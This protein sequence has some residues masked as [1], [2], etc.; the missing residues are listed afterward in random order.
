[1]DSIALIVI[2]CV[3]MLGCATISVRIQK[4][5]PIEQDYNIQDNTVSK[6]SVANTHDT[7]SSQRDIETN[8]SQ[9]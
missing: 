3:L 1:M 9:N 7:G 8:K 4:D 6:G 5:N 2:F